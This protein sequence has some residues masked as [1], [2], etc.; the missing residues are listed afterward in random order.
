MCFNQYSPISH[1][2]QASQKPAFLNGTLVFGDHF[3][4]EAS[5]KS[6]ALESE[7]SLC[8]VSA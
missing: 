2:Q 8:G 5:A 7:L 6:Q 1:L 4:S 3:S